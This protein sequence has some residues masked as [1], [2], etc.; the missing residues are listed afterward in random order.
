MVSALRKLFPKVCTCCR[1]R[2]F[3]G[4][5]TEKELTVLGIESSCDDTGVGVVTS[6]KR[7]LGQAAFSQLPVHLKYVTKTEKN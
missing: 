4:I 7:V 5:C 2:I 1:R 3:R 6:S